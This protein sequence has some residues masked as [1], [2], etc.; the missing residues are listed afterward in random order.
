MTQT[1]H[2]IAQVI[3]DKSGDIISESVVHKKTLKRAD[4]IN[5]FG[6]RHR[7]QIDLMRCSQD[8]FL[9]HQCHLFND[10]LDCPTCGKKLR[11]QG[12]VQSDFHDVFTDHKV[13][14][15]RL[16]CTCGWKNKTTINSIYG[17]ASH[18]ELI[19]I[20]VTTGANHS[21]AK[22]STL[23][24]THSVIPRKINNDVTIMRVTI[25]RNVT[26]IG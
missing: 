15:A 21:F 17:N 14:V 13:K 24:N 8:F 26:K 19:K 11:K 22:A 10:D 20:Q 4:D 2:Y 1:I 5:E 6:L 3:D 12:S 7:E 16:T 9:K 18:P 25:M 23:L